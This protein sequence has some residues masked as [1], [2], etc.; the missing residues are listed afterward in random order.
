M[1]LVCWVEAQMYT[2]GG[3]S[4]ECVNCRIVHTNIH[5]RA[6]ERQQTPLTLEQ[7][8]TYTN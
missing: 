2:L 4:F 6:V 5:E 1:C 8:S 7:S 3:N